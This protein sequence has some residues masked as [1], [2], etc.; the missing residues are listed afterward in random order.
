MTAIT[1][2]PPGWY[3]DPE[4][5]GQLRWWDGVAWTEYRSA[6]AEAT[7]AAPE[8][9][10]AA[11]APVAVSAG[12]EASAAGAAGLGIAAAGA[13]GLGTAAAAHHPPAVYQPVVATMTQ[14]SAAAR[15]VPELASAGDRL[16]A[17]I[18]DVAVG[19]V[20]IIT[21]SI[22]SAII[23]AASDVLG[24]LVSLIGVVGYWALLFISAVMGEGRLGQSYGR[25][26]LG[27]KVV[28][29]RDGGPIGS[30]AA[31]GRGIV[32]GIGCY[33]FLLG[34]L[35]ILW[36][37]QRQGWHDK[38]V[39]SVVVKAPSGPKMDPVTYVRAIFST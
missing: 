33:V 3:D 12:F 2:P 37:P 5:A 6:P 14:A 38:A 29:I 7:A 28:S 31:L 21:V 27:L 15:A 34:V 36:D 24:G 20:L 19:F 39:G 26:L 30:P 23:G 11:D 4:Q 16:L 22:I 13:A 32:R 25:H 1:P 10:A 18:V 9:P 8:T 35:W 17:M